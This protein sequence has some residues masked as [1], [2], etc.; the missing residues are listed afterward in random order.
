M[1]VHPGTEGT[2]SSRGAPN[3]VLL[4]TVTFWGR[5]APFLSSGAGVCGEV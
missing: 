5:F 4:A 2:V 1:L 3:P